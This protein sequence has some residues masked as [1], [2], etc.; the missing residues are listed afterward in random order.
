MK[1]LLACILLLTTTVSFGQHVEIVENYPYNQMPTYDYVDLY[2]VSN[3]RI[4]FDSKWGRNF[5]GTT[6]YVCAIKNKFSVIYTDL[7]GEGA[8]FDLT[9][10]SPVK[11]ETDA[12]GFE[13]H[14]FTA[15]SKS[16]T[17]WIIE[18]SPIS[19]K[20]YSN[21][22]YWHVGKYDGDILRNGIVLKEKQ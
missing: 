1:N 22:A 19:V 9:I 4:D 21:R 11:I 5:R 10:N 7:S 15:I 18:F 17:E 16:N 20:I 2:S 6:V 12:I 3:S 13:L 8:L 14:T